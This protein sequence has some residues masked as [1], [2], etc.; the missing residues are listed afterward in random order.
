MARES[1]YVRG[2]IIRDI[3]LLVD[4]TMPSDTLPFRRW[5][6]HTASV[7]KGLLRYYALDLMREKPMSGSEIMEEIARQTGGRWKPSPGSV[8]PLLRRLH[9]SSYSEQV[10]TEEPGLKRY[11]LTEKGEIL[12]Q[13]QTELKEELQKK[14][15]TVVRQL[16]GGFWL[17]P[18]PSKLR[19]LGEPTRRFARAIFDLRRTVEAKPTEPILKEVAEFLDKTA[20]EI[21]ELNGTIKEGED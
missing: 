16:L 15:E 18:D 1:L 12:F 11:K 21:E 10:P 9:E 7:P 17:S 6:R 2:R 20:A 8:Y 19:K 3:T 4:G 14:L 5:A 13:E